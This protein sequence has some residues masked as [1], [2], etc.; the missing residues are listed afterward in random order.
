MIEIAA[1]RA[2]RI[3]FAV[4]ADTERLFECMGRAR[5]AAEAAG[6]DPTELRFGAFVNCVIHPDREV[7]REAIRGGLST[8]AHFSGFEGMDI[9]SLPEGARAAA[10]HLRSSYDMANHGVAAGAHAQAL[11]AEFI[12]RFGIAGPLEEAIAR[13]QEIREV[14]ID[15]V[16]VV[17]GSRDMP[18]EVAGASLPALAKVVGEFSS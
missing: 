5:G 18:P 14:G 11:D 2:D 6:R 8:F 17:P 10:R 1:R 7:A 16:R 3:C 15:F 13:F 12:H 4:G 9:E